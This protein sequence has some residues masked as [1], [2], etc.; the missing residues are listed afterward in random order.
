MGSQ[1]RRSPEITGNTKYKQRLGDHNR[2]Y[3]RD[4][5]IATKRL[6]GV[7]ARSRDSDACCPR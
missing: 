5:T 3:C 6:A 1:S 7:N 2:A 4:D